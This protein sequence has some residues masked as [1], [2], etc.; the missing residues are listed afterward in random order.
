MVFSKDQFLKSNFSCRLSIAIS[1]NIKHVHPVLTE[2][3]VVLYRD[4]GNF[5]PPLFF[6]YNVSFI[7]YFCL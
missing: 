1:F 3:L 2:P 7:M 5:F 4:K 6:V